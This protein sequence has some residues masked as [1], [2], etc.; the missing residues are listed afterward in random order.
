MWTARGHITDIHCHLL[1]GLDDGPATMD[2]SLAMARRAVADGTGTVVCTPHMHPTYPTH[3]DAVHTGVARLADALRE[4]DIP[5]RVLPGGEISHLHL[6]E[7]SIAQVRRASLGAEGRWV[8]LE[9]PFRDWPQELPRIIRTLGN[10]GLGTILAHPER[11][12]PV[13]DDPFLLQPL[14]AMGALAQVTAASLTGGHG[15]D[16][17]RTARDLIDLRLVHVVASDGHS[18]D[19]RP[20]LIMDGLRAASDHMG[21]SAHHALRMAEDVPAALAAPM[22]PAA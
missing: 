21:T 16:A 10:R 3:P 15:P 13:Q 18:A 17:A 12:E 9:V 22:A 5:L 8:L 6:P 4:A 1:P 7:M 14:I 2:D 20:P 19:W 11:S